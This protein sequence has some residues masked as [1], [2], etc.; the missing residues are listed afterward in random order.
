MLSVV[1]TPRWSLNSVGA[2]RNHCLAFILFMNCQWRGSR[3]KEKC[4]EENI[5]MGSW[6]RGK[7]IEQATVDKLPDVCSLDLSSQ[8][9]GNLNPSYAL[10]CLVTESW[11]ALSR[12]HIL[13]PGGGGFLARRGRPMAALF[14]W[15]IWTGTLY[16]ADFWLL[17][18]L[19]P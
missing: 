13:L 10:T 19:E 1:S 18:T 12:H 6:N 17:S 16:W 2:R 7:E 9:D 8:W 3:W 5:A 4:L 11:V 14:S 15:E